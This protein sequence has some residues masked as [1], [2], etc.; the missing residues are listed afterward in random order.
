M[1]GSLARIL[2]QTAI[3]TFLQFSLSTNYLLF[4]SLLPVTEVSPQRAADPSSCRCATGQIPFTASI[5]HSLCQR[6]CATHPWTCCCL[7]CCCWLHC[8]SSCSTAS[9]MVQSTHFW[10]HRWM[11]SWVSWYDVQRY[12]FLVSYRCLINYKSKGREC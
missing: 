8:N 6:G 11:I 3:D 5:L 10:V 2:G 1:G 9:C 7:L 4:L 12:S